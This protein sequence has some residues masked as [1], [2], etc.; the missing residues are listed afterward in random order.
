MWTSPSRRSQMRNS[1]LVEAALHLKGLVTWTWAS[2]NTFKINHRWATF[3]SSTAC[4]S[5][6]CMHQVISTSWCSTRYLTW[7]IALGKKCQTKIF[8]IWRRIRVLLRRRMAS[9]FWHFTGW[10]MTDNWFSMSKIVYLKQSSDS[11]MRHSTRE[12]VCFSTP[13]EGRA[14]RQLSP[15]FTLWKS[16]NGPFSKHWSS[17]TLAVQILKSEQTS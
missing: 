11:S 15:S 8:L 4:S 9:N 12:Q 1:L 13:S 3:A 17:W 16:F 2:T 14:D 7:W 5:E 10:M 6:T